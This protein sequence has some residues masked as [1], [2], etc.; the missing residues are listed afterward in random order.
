FSHR[1]WQADGPQAEAYNSPTTLGA[2]SLSQWREH[3]GRRQGFCRPS[4]DHS[5]APLVTTPT[6]TLPKSLQPS[7]EALLTPAGWSFRAARSASG[8]EIPQMR[9][10]IAEDRGGRPQL[11]SLR[12][13]FAV[14]G[15]GF[16]PAAFFYR[17]G[18]HTGSLAC[19]VGP[20]LR[21]DTSAHCSVKLCLPVS[22]LLD[23]HE[24][25]GQ[26]GVVRDQPLRQG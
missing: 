19:A 4:C 7:D 17:C 12:Q 26:R 11:A 23:V 24:H 15:A 13:I 22:G 1:S 6:L 14:Q 16:F 25:L 5:S 10:V 9:C 2:H 20:H 21:G 8:G 18:H 3:S